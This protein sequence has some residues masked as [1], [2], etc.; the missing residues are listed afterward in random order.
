MSLEIW[1]LFC[2]TDLLL[3]LMPGPGV[4][5]IMSQTLTHGRQSGFAATQ[6]ILAANLVYF[7]LAAAGLITILKSSATA[8]ELLK[9]LGA[10]YLVYLGLKLIITP[11]KRELK[12]KKS[13]SK[14]KSFW[15]GFII[16]GF[17]PKVLLF[18]S[19][20]LPQFIVLNEPINNQLILLGVSA[21]VIQ[22]A[23]LFSYS[24]LADKSSN[25]LGVRFRQAFN[26]TS[27]ILLLFAGLG[28]AILK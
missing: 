17:N 7:F 20:I 22:S 3:C 25:I 9:Y 2:L 19:A 15:Q 16:H 26:K 4:L 13:N 28:L 21:L 12:R 8:F 24:L 6:G 27:G 11:T 10:A 23:V 14:N 5:L 18:F 1:L